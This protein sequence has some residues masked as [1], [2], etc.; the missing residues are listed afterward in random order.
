MNIEDIK[1]Y[2]SNKKELDTLCQK[3]FKENGED[4]QYYNGWDF[5][6]N[7]D[8]I[9]ITYTYQD[10]WSNTE[11]YTEVDTIKVTYNELLKL[12]KV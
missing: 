10:F 2:K 6:E 12:Q 1:N 5:I 9:R 4:W 8:A 7:E 11:M 3:W